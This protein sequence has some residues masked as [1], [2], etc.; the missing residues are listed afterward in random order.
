MITPYRLSEKV[1]DSTWLESCGFCISVYWRLLA[2][3]FLL[4]LHRGTIQPKPYK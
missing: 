3:L 1:A 4:I 2:V